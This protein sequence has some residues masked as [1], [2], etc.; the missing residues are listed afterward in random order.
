MSY[1]SSTGIKIA[2][3]NRYNTTDTLIAKHISFRKHLF[4]GMFHSQST[5]AEP[6]CYDPSPG[7]ICFPVLSE[8]VVVPRLRVAQRGHVD[9]GHVPPTVPGAVEKVKSMEFLGSLKK[10]GGR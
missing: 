6:H 7:F 1:A 8:L 3:I 9:F 10:K 5:S 2:A 4:E